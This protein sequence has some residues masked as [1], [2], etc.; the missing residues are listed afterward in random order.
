LLHH[1]ERIRH[2]SALFLALFAPFSTDIALPPHSLILGYQIPPGS[3]AVKTKRE[4]GGGQL[5]GM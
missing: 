4:E 5:Y 2:H 1:D 3:A